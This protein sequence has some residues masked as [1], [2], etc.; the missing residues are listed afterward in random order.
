M[1]KAGAFKSRGATNAV[2]SLSD[3]EVENGVATHSSG[4]HA[5]ALALAANRRGIPAHIVMNETAPQAKKDAVRD[6]GGRITFCPPVEQERKAALER[7]VKE[8][9]AAFIHPYDNFQ[10]VSG[11]GTAAVEL[12]EDAN[13]LDIVMTP[14][15]GGGLLS[16]TAIATKAINPNVQVIAAEP[17][18]A[19]DAQLSFRSGELHPA[20]K[21]TTIADGLLTSLSPFTFSIIRRYADDVLT[22]NEKNIVRAMR[23]IWERMKIITEPSGAV[24]LGVVLQHPGVF[25]NKRV[26]IIISGGN[27]D[28]S[29]LPF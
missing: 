10:V 5:G 20:L 19:R 22:V 3:E 18:L 24:P 29:H 16:G 27:A 15:G 6:Y 17:Y 25:Y 13:N 14:V 11:Q 8:T 21:P 1:Q 12:L 28:L 9:G 26:G 23:L 2:F 7:V 4:N